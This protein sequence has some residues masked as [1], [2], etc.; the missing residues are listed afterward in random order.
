MPQPCLFQPW[1]TVNSALQR[2][3]SIQGS[4]TVRTAEISAS[5]WMDPGADAC[6]EKD[7]SSIQITKV[8]LRPQMTHLLKLQK[9]QKQK[10]LPRKHQPRPLSPRVHQVRSRWLPQFSFFL[11]VLPR[12]A[13]TS[14][15]GKIVW[16][17]TRPC[18]QCWPQGPFFVPS[19]PK[20]FFVAVAFYSGWGL[21]HFTFLPLSETSAWPIDVKW[22]K[23]FFD[24]LLFKTTA[25]QKQPQ[26]AHQ[27]FKNVTEQP[28]N[29]TS[30]LRA[31]FWMLCVNVHLFCAVPIRKEFFLE[32]IVGLVRKRESKVLPSFLESVVPMFSAG[33]TSTP[34]QDSG[35]FDRFISTFTTT[36]Q[37][38]EVSV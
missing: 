33:S 23:S 30:Q 15:K 13:V 3:S 28:S 32:E 22:H 9:N 4:V 37:Q 19:L 5:M 8:V 26:N 11:E 10:P 7:G 2:V 1:T 31:S 24:M 17:G 27:L 14:K 6:A 18:D 34:S 12:R 38:L 35:P 20:T 25:L 29:L 16:I 21:V 36:S